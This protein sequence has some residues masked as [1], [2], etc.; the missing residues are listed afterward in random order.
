MNKIILLIIL[1]IFTIVILFIFNKLLNK[2]K[3]NE[4]FENDTLLIEDSI[5]GK[6]KCFVKDTVICKSIKS[7]KAW[8]KHI[9]EEI[10]KYYKEGTLFL[11]IGSNYGTH[12][13]YIANIIKN[14]N[15]SGKVYSFDIQPKIIELFKE[16][17]KINELN[18]YINLY[19]FGLGDTNKTMELI[20]P[21]DYN[22]HSNPGMISLTNNNLNNNDTKINVPIKKLD[23]LNISEPISIIKID[24]EG[25]ELEAFQGGIETI[26]KNKPY[27][28]IE[29]WEHNKDKYFNWINN[30]FSFYKIQNISAH[31]YLLIP[32]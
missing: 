32:D 25:F 12:S 3:K 14:N 24:V 19:E 28:L 6:F 18:D 22:N 26:K 16:N 13:I 5:Y 4:N 2:F 23:D 15:Q 7:S 20:I 10:A 21:N 11:D 17:I 29:I 8:E 1:S 30:N 27:I 9:S 31:D